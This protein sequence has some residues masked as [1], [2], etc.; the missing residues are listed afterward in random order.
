MAALSSNQLAILTCRA[1]AGRAGACRAGFCPDDT[2][3]ATPGTKGPRYLWS[4][5]YVA[6]SNVW[7]KVR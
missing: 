4:Q 6:L 3:G 5:V 7:T 2:R 1:G